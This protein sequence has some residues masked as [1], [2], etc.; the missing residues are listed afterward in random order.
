MLKVLLTTILIGSSIGGIAAGQAQAAVT[1]ADYDVYATGSAHI[2]GGSYGVIASGSFSD[3]NGAGATNFISNTASTPALD[4][5]ADALSLAYANLAVTGTV[6]T[7]QYT[8]GAATLTG[9][10]SGINVFDIDGSQYSGLY[11]L[12]FAGLGTGAIVNISGASLGNFVNINYGSLSP[13]QVV[14]NFFQADTVSMNGMNVLGSILAPGAQVRLQGG[15][16]AGTVV[17]DSFYSE[18]TRIGG[19]AFTGFAGEQT[20]PVPEPATW[21]MMIAGFGLIGGAMR[22]RRAKIRSARLAGS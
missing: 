3:S 5:Q 17:A 7:G 22:W 1:L 13:D 9:A 6:T 11:A 21:A 2:S 12:S 19:D 15:S 16:V 20:P 4:A 8:P 10:S 14:L 18:G